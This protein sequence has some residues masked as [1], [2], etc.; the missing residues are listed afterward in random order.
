LF[1]RFTAADLRADSAGIRTVQE[2]VEV[3]S[4][5]FTASVR[6]WH[7]KVY[8]CVVSP[9]RKGSSTWACDDR[10]CT[11]VIAVTGLAAI[12]IYFES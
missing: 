3:I 7:A 1:A 2:V 6:K 9:P 12:L 4:V 8:L 5:S 11:D 10:L